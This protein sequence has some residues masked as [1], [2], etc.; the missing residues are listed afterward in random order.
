[1]TFW[2]HLL[3]VAL[4]S[5]TCHVASPS[6]VTFLVPFTQT[7]FF[8]SRT[9]I[10]L[11]HD[12][13]LVAF[14]SYQSWISS[15]P[16]T[17]LFLVAIGILRELWTALC[18]SPMSYLGF[19]SDCFNNRYHVSVVWD[20]R[21]IL[22]RS[23]LSFDMRSNLTYLVRKVILTGILVFSVSSSV[24]SNLTINPST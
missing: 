11:S 7:C 13:F 10:S 23:R 16:P 6:W 4:W 3:L 12:C 20:S 24:L 5:T 14:F 15:T 8:F 18:L 17:F 1:M 2:R 21:N 9:V 22:T 19:V